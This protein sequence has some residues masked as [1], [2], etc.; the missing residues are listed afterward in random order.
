MKM[1]IK[2]TVVII[3]ECH[4]YQ[5]HTKIYPLSLSEDARFEVFTGV[6]VNFV[7]FLPGSCAV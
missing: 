3:E 2:L 6:K 5:L 4:C 7:F 1:M